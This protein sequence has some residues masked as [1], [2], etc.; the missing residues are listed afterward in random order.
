VTGAD[1]ER[2]RKLVEQEITTLVISTDSDLFKYLKAM[3]PDGDVPAPRSA[4]N[5]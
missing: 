4:N 1:P 5:R 2:G 3:T